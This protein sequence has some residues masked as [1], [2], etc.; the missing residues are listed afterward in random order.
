MESV[1]DAKP[2]GRA[3]TG[4]ENENDADRQQR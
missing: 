3:R 4:S 1:A 2:R